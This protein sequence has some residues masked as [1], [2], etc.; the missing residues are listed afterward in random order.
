[1]RALVGFIDHSQL[2]AVGRSKTERPGF[3]FH[4]GPTQGVGIVT[5]KCIRRRIPRRANPF[6]VSSRRPGNAGGGGQPR[7]WPPRRTGS[8][9]HGA[10]PRRQPPRPAGG[11]AQALGTGS[12]LH[13]KFK[14]RNRCKLRP[15]ASRR[16][17]RAPCRLRRRRAAVAAA[18]RRR[19][20]A[21]ARRGDS[22]SDAAGV[23]VTAH[24]ALVVPLHSGSAARGTPTGHRDAAGRRP[25]GPVA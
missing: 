15:R 7:H 23:K 11:S 3:K 4:P 2:S 12:G 10:A 17:E 8:A 24:H 18:A 5:N 14:F 25:A 1:M 16:R 21:R 6:P 22:D 20:Q 13:H 19:R 9:G